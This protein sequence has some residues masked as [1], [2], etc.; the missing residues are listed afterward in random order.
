[1]NEFGVVYSVSRFDL[2]NFEYR[3]T[4]HSCKA[5]LLRDVMELLLGLVR[6]NRAGDLKSTVKMRDDLEH[7]ES[8]AGEVV[9][10]LGGER[11]EY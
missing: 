6:P 3:N 10:K 11:D 5:F 4:V 9:V 8:R 2:I 1:M 7:V